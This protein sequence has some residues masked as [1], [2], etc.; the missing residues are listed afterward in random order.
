M[1]AT[2][3]KTSA[4]LALHSVVVASA[5]LIK[6]MYS[7]HRKTRKSFDI[8]GEAHELTFSCHRKLPLLSSDKERLI[9]LEAIDTA[10]EKLQFELWAYVIMPTHVHL[11]ILPLNEQTTVARI[12]HA[13]KRSSAQDI[14]SMWKQEDN[15]LLT[16]VRINSSSFRIWMPGGGYDR[17]MTTPQATQASID[18]IHSN[19]VVRH[20][21]PN[22]LEWPWSSAR[23]YAGLPDSKIKVDFY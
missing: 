21:A 9:V 12:L 18:Y 15:P 2:G 1:G 20:L 8:L 19:P 23:A 6:T 14:L 7:S 16:Q 5:G 4:Y 22:A 11:L 10:R 13:I 3:R 17:N